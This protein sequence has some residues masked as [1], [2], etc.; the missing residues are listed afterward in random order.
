MGII[1]SIESDTESP[2]K[3]DPRTLHRETLDRWTWR[4]L[5]YGLLL[6]YTTITVTMDII[7]DTIT[8]TITIRA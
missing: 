2:G 4:T 7:T 8:I 3:F 6:V 5:H 1:I